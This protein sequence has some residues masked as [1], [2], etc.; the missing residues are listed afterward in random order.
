[1]AELPLRHAIALGLLHGPT[2]LL[3]VSS[4]GHSTV[5]P[6][7]ARWPAAELEPELR[8]S[9]EVALHA[10]SAA[11]LA[12]LMRGEIR[13]TLRD[14]DQRGAALIAL[15]FTA[16]VIV[17]VTLERPIEQRWSGPGTIAVGLVLGGLAMAIAD[18]RGAGSRALEDAGA[19]DGLLLGL[20]QSSAL[21]PGVSR[22]GATLA[23][24]RARGFGREDAATLSWRV[25]LPVILG[26]TAL[27]GHRLA[28]RCVPAE[29][30][31][32]LVVGAAG[33][34]FSTL[35]CAPLIREGRRGRSLRPFVLYRGAL[36]LA[37]LRRRR[38]AHNGGA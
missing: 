8:K 1:V 24:A 26:A 36:A 18:T 4:S 37:V 6:W 13:R 27:K 19:L 10:G 30:R 33:A 16:P 25:A 2:E 29:I 22:N 20:A 17:G 12:I 21:L 32:P 14:L 11:A 3:P 5:I 34:F 7:L 38:A 28:Q 15:S 31:G 9:F 35:A 23:A